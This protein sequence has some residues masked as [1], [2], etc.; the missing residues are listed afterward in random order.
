M[1]ETW[2]QRWLLLIW[3]L[4]ALVTAVWSY[5][6]VDPNLTLFAW[7]PFVEWQTWMWSQARNVAAVTWQYIVLLGVWWTAYAFTVQ[8]SR[9]GPERIIPRWALLALAGS[10]GFLWLGQNAL[11]HDI[12]NYLFNA[13]MVVQYQANPHVAV[14]LDFAH[15]PWTRFMHNTHTAAPYG[16]G[17]TLLSLLPYVLSGGKFLLAYF[18]MKLWMIVGLVLYLGSIW[19][20]ARQHFPR[21]A[22]WRWSLVAFH[23]L[24][25]IE[26]VLMG[27]N[28]VWM[29]WPVLVA[30]NWL[31]CQKSKHVWWKVALS[32]VLFGLSI[33]IKLATI[34]LVP[35][36]V[37]W[38]LPNGWDQRI[39]SLFVGAKRSDQLLRFARR[40]QADIAAGLLLVPL[41]TA[42]SQQFH[43][44]YFIWVLSFVP[45]TRA[46]W[47]RATLLGLSV[48]STFRYIPLMFAGWEYSPLVQTQMRIV[49]W[50]GA[51]LGLG[52]F[53]LWKYIRQ[54]RA[55]K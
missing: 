40:Y 8:S 6:W 34:V 27:H 31:C 28:D 26:T 20:I 41:M 32:I 33:W 16:W 47:W 48:S 45:F 13:K 50:S 23:P 51:F 7:G 36:L 5:H 29:M 53:W 52:S 30:M 55:S 3:W 9:R 4:V 43:P 2:K 19:S 37:W 25:L 42:R 22:W 46:Q 39:V 11:S 17:W 24:L 15:D 14:A 1:N 21:S 38:L 54:L 12:F 18:G 49:T 44:W 35:F 10:I